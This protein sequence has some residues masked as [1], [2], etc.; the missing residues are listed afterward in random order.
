MPNAYERIRLM[1]NGL[2]ADSPAEV[3]KKRCVLFAHIDQSVPGWEGCWSSF[4][5][6]TKKSGL[7]K[8][9]DKVYLGVTGDSPLKE[10]TLPVSYLFMSTGSDPY[11]NLGA[12][13]VIKRINEFSYVL[14]RVILYI[15]FSAGYN[16]I[17]NIDEM[18]YRMN[19]EV[20][21]SGPN[22]FSSYSTHIARNP[23]E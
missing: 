12:S 20:K 7:S 10:S 17:M 9:L 14:K 23:C 3:L 8:L 5:Q 22:W 11:P 6:D 13:E 18:L 16:P 4:L 1:C 19:R 2:G 15:D 21:V